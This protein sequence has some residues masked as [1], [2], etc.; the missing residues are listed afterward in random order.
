MYI[1]IFAK[2]LKDGRDFVAQSHVP[3]VR[4]LNIF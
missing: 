2:T 3:Q 1:L 4:I